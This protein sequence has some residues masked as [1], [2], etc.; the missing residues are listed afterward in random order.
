MIPGPTGT[1]I[2][3]LIAV[4]LVLAILL[5]LGVNIDVNT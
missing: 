4:A 3:F 1:F 2:W 5:M